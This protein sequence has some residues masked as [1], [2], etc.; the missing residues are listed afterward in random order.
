MKMANG[1]L[2][3]IVLPNYNVTNVEGTGISFGFGHAAEILVRPD[4]TATFYEYGLYANNA[5]NSPFI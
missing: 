3:S 5:Q 4:G 2:I 1:A